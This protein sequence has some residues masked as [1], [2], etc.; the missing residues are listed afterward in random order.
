MSSTIEKL[1]YLAVATRFRSISEKLY[2][3]GDKIYQEAGILFKASWFPV[4]YVLALAES[5]LTILQISEQIDFSHITVKNV[6]REL[7]TEE[8]V[9]IET[10]PADRRSKLVSLSIKGQK[11]IYRLKPIWI[12]FAT[13]LKKKFQS[14]H[15]D[16]INIL[17]RIDQQIE[18][19]PI[20]KMV[21]EPEADAVAILDYSP[22]LKKQFHELAGQR[23]A[24]EH[25]DLLKEED[26]MALENPS[27]THFMKGG[28][29]FYARFRDKIVGFEALKRVD[30]Q[31]FE[32]TQPHIH[33][34]Y[35]KLDIEKK[36]LE[37]SISRCNENQARELWIQ[38][39][40]K[41]TEGYEIYKILGFMDEIAHP[42][43]VIHDHTKRIMC[44]KL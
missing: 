41:K 21:I 36:L 7:M 31:A 4:Y 13:A 35:R 43:M 1:G 39:S 17:K 20:Y 5:P 32:F 30:D 2:V 8:L 3:D 16:F 22:G 42:K 23:L 12:A 25:T 9:N 29:Y 44:L 14:G 40:V 11:L 24:E 10:N 15:P 26:G 38:T 19:T 34:S 28:F 37:R 6:L 33:P 27:E 18:A